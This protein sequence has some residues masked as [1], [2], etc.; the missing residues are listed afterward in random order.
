MSTWWHHQKLL[1]TAV[2]PATVTPY[3]RG[4]L[5]SSITEV[6][7]SLWMLCEERG[8]LRAH[9]HCRKIVQR[10]S[11]VSINLLKAKNAHK[12]QE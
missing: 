9:C 5:S 6:F 10:N 1:H 11:F 3:D 2:R 8:L 7:G 12:T 4:Q